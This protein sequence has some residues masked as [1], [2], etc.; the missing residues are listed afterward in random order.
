MRYILTEEKINE[1]LNNSAFVLPDSPT[2]RGMSPGQIKERLYKPVIMLAN[3]IRNILISISNDAEATDKAVAS[4][5]GQIE[6]IY[7]TAEN[8]AK[9]VEN[10]AKW[11]QSAKG[12]LEEC[13]E[14]LMAVQDKA[15]SAY[16]LAIGKSKVH[17]YYD[18]MTMFY[19]LKTAGVNKG[20]FILILDRECPDFVVS[21]LDPTEYTYAEAIYEGNVDE[22]VLQMYKP[23]AGLT[24]CLGYVG[25]NPVVITGIES[26]IDT[27]AFATK[28]ELNAINYH[29]GDYEWRVNE[30]TERISSLDSDVEIAQELAQSAFDR[31]GGIYEAFSNGDEV[32]V[33]NGTM[34]V[35]PEPINELLI[36]FPSDN[37]TCGFQ[38]TFADSGTVGVAFG[39]SSTFPLKFIGDPPTFANGETWELNIC[40]GVVVGGKI[41]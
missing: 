24:Y 32:V 26:G 41:G 9:E 33:S 1:I 18:F 39:S 2:Q 19:G 15:V 12:M 17:I 29:I 7:T 5:S 35:A 34:Y 40:N 22:A 27:S 8:S 10:I 16:N 20:D 3:A 14:Q 13:T 37:F 30:N 6:K 28:E 25:A 31:A 4:T 23:G 11:V 36:T 38:F 21:S